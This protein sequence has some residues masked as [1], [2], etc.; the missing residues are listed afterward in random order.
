[1][2]SEILLLKVDLLFNVANN[3]IIRFLLWL[4]GDANI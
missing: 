4:Q 3:I 2:E 1:L